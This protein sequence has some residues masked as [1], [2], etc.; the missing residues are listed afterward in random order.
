MLSAVYRDEGDLA[1]SVSEVREA[2]RLA[3]GSADGWNA[4]G[5]LLTAGGRDSEAEAAYRSALK[6]RPDDPDALFN[7]AELLQRAK[8]TAEARVLLERLVAKRPSFPGAATALEAARREGAAPGPG[9]VH[10][11]LLRVATRAD[12]DEVLRRLAAGEDFAALAR[13]RSTDPSASRGG[14]LGL[15][16]PGELAEALRSA[17]ASLAV[18]AH[19]AALETPAGYVILRREQ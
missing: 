11:S 13:A 8:R 12:A 3:P 9:Q 1:K 19:S 14:D 17:A 10:L 7:L 2:V 18:G 6:A 4:L 15:I 16:R 5:L